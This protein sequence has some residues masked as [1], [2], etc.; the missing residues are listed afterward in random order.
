[1]YSPDQ[2]GL[3]DSDGTRASS[4]GNTRQVLAR[5]GHIAHEVCAKGLQCGTGAKEAEHDLSTT[6]TALSHRTD[7]DPVHGNSAGFYSKTAFK[8]SQAVVPGTSPTSN[9][10]LHA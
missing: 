4:S 9:E 1:M 10:V 7:E 8:T 6:S 5:G 3:E 2:S